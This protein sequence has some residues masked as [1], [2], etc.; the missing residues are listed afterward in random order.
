VQGILH[1]IKV[2]GPIACQN[3]TDCVVLYLDQSAT[4][5]LSEALIKQN[6]PLIPGQ[7]RLARVLQPGL[8]TA[9]DP[10]PVNGAPIS[11]GEKRCILTYIALKFT[12]QQLKRPWQDSDWQTFYAFA[13]KT[14]QDG[15]INVAEPSI[16][17]PVV[18]PPLNKELDRLLKIFRG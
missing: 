3:K 15:G 1:S 9:Y 18:A 13:E 7:P 2:A 16:D 5:A 17:G 11:F 12:S 10:P 14:L 8:S 6:L 4:Q